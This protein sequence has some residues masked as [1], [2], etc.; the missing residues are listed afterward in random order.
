MVIHRPLSLPNNRPAEGLSEMKKV[1]F[2]DRDGVIN[3][4]SEHYIK[5]WDEF[6]F[7]QGS[8]DAMRLLHENGFSVLV[9]TN[10]SM[11]NRKMVPLNTLLHMH[12]NLMASVKKHGGKITDI[13]FCPHR[14]DENCDCRKPEPG[15]IFQ[16]KTVHGI[17]LDR[18]VMVGDSTKDI[19]CAKN[20]GCKH[21]ILVKTGN[22]P[23]AIDYFSGKT[24][25]PDHIADNLLD[26]ATWIV[27]ML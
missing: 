24:S 1:V 5:S 15:L 22:G 21:S 26:A 2:L 14:P 20:A 12:Q 7:L 8:L 11:I 27:S 17:H 10:Q 4:D 6:H 25:G 16:A 9:I 18:S 3:Q 13:F 23:A 19:L